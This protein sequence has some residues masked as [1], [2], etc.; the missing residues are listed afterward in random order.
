MINKV[1]IRLDKYAQAGMHPCC[2]F[3]TKSD[4][5]SMRPDLLLGARAY[6]FSNFVQ[7]PEHIDIYFNATIFS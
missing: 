5:L 3:A 1:L 4:F 2:L 7:I 6:I